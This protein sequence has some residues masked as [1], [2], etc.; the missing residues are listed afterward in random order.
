MLFSVYLYRC[1]LSHD[2]IY[3]FALCGSSAYRKRHMP[4]RLD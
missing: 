4:K 3:I 2:H 1:L